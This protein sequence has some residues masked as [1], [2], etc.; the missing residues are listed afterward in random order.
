V[1]EAVD[2]SVSPPVTGPRTKRGPLWVLAL[3]GF[4]IIATA[5]FIVHRQDSAGVDHRYEIPSGTADRLDAGETVA[6]VPDELHF[7]PGDKLT[8][9]NDDDRRH[10]LGVLSVDPGETVSYSFPNKGVFNGACT[11][12]NTGKVTIY[13]E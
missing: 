9:V 7:A 11:L 8:L 6:I 2:A 4:L 13:V 1:T 5:A 3:G 12:H 10:E